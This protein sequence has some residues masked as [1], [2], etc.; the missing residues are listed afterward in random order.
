M[1]GKIPQIP[2]FRSVLIFRVAVLEA[3]HLSMGNRITRAFLA[4]ALSG[5]AFSPAALA[6][7]TWTGVL[8]DSMCKLRHESGA[9]GQDTTDADC[10]RD[11]VKGGSKYVL[12]VG[13]AA[14]AILNQSHPGLPAHAGARV[15]VTGTQRTDGVEVATIE[16]AR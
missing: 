4:A 14:H 5:A 3:A 15:V 11:C 12:V 2:R 1:F 13:G 8:S 10:T 16:Q 6:E 9:E 7:Q